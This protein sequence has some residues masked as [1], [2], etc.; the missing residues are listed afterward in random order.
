L[1]LIGS[2]VGLNDASLKQL[3]D[4]MRGYL[5]PWLEGTN[6]DALRYDQTYGGI[7]ST[8]GLRDQGADLDKRTTTSQLSAAA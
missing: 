1:V 2:E 7:V 5:T 4:I 3:L 6:P 8:D